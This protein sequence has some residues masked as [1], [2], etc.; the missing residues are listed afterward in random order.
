MR[1]LFLVG[2][3]GIAN[4]HAEVIAR[5]VGLQIAGVCDI[6]RGKA[7]KFVARHKL[8]AA[9]FADAAAGLDAVRP[10]YVVLLTPRGVRKQIVELCVERKLPLIMEKPPCHDLAT[11]EANRRMLEES[12]LVHSVAF[13]TRYDQALNTTLEKMRANQEVLSLVS[14][15]F[16]SPMARQP[17]YDHYPDPYLVER[18]GGLVGDQGI[19]YID[20]ARYIAGSEAAKVCALGT[21]RL[22]PPSDK[23]TTCDTAGWVIEMKNGVIVSHG[24]TWNAKGWLCQIQLV[25]DRGSV[26]VD[27]FRNSASG[28]LNGEPYNFT[29][30]RPDV[31]QSFELE[32]RA[33]LHAVETGEM[34]GIRSP[35]ADALESFKLAEEINRQV[36][37]R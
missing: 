36:Y 27:S 30:T 3:G 33:F 34:S 10:D 15:V 11:G 14:I 18:S 26:V 12:R 5:I 35:Y 22:L 8:D 20:V 16:Q 28:T 1:R 37:G 9:V 17:M 6:V 31:T 24:H 4:R 13:P 29:G 7:E 21:N 2:A 23:V 19:H 25:T 32:H